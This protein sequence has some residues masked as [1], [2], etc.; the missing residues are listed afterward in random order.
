MNRPYIVFVSLALLM[1]GC[2]SKQITSDQIELGSLEPGAEIRATLQLTNPF[3]TMARVTGLDKTCGVAVKVPNNGIIEPGQTI[4]LDIQGHAPRIPGPGAARVVL[5]IKS[6]NQEVP[7]ER[8]ID[9]LILARPFLDRTEIWLREGKGNVN[10]FGQDSSTPGSCSASPGLLCSVSGSMIQVTAQ[11]SLQKPGYVTV[12]FGTQ[13]FILPVKNDIDAGDI[14]IYPQVVCATR[15]KTT[16]IKIVGFRKGLKIESKDDHL[17]VRID[18]YSGLIHIFS[19]VSLSTEIWLTQN[20][21]EVCRAQ[22]YIE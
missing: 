17:A 16:I 7:Y 2:Q 9:Y 8:Q 13:E 14:R 20:G 11:H 19:S 4:E 10:L 21:K 6:G 18:Q 15:G 1:F 5:G 12:H 22:V 3:K